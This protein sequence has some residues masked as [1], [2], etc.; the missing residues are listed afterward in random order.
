MLDNKILIN[1]K[2]YVLLSNICLPLYK[3]KLHTYY[4]V[5]AHTHVDL[6]VT[7]GNSPKSCL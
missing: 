5:I 6:K 2:N 4:Y 7:E 3:F 1:D